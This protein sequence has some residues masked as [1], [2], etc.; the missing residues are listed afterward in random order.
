HVLEVLLA[1]AVERRLAQGGD[2]S[3]EGVAGAAGVGFGEPAVDVAA[4]VQQGD[5]LG[6]D[7]GAVG[8]RFSPPVLLCGRDRLHYPATGT[9][10]PQTYRCRRG[11]GRDVSG[12]AAVARTPCAWYWRAVD[13]RAG[14]LG[15]A[16]RKIGCILVMCRANV[17]TFE[18]FGYSLS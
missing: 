1:D 15:A 16:L 17:A 7:V 13:D 6:V 11:A 18:R 9:N 12:G 4:D 10:R 14:P 8:H 3:G 5:A 2:L